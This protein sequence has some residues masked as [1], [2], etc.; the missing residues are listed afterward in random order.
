MYISIIKKNDTI[1]TQ[2]K[3]FSHP[4]WK[5]KNVPVLTSIKSI[6]KEIVENEMFDFC[7]S[8][9]NECISNI[10]IDQPKEMIEEPSAPKTHNFIT[11]KKKQI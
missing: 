4:H 7:K 5:A 6:P 9:I 8:I 2:H 1:K 11:N 10:D 3:K